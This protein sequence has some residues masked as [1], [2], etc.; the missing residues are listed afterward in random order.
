[1][2][3]FHWIKLSW[4]SCFMWEKLG[5]LNWFWQFLCEGL[6]SFNSKGLYYSYTW[7]CSSCEQRAS[8][9]M[10]LI[11]RKLCRFL[12]MFLTDF[13]L[14]SVLLLFPLLITFFAFMHSFWCYLRF[15]RS[16]HLLMCLSL[17]TLTPIIRGV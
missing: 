15:S 2:W 1:M 12:H 16:T 17:K 5:W 14:F 9:C 10:G 13:T 8:F 7:S 6:S 11:S 3:I 4:H